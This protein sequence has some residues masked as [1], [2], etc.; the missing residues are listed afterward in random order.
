MRSIQRITWLSPDMS[1]TCPH[2]ARVAHQMSNYSLPEKVVPVAVSFS[3]ACLLACER[4]RRF[5][6]QWRVS[7]SAARVGMISPQPTLWGDE[8]IGRGAVKDRSLAEL[9]SLLWTHSSNWKKHQ[10]NI[11][12][13]NFVSITNVSWIYLYENLTIINITLESSLLD[14]GIP[15]PRIFTKND[16]DLMWKPIMFLF[17]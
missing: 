4:E 6:E 13:K 9:S 2:S 8:S 1:E 17:Y 12:L 14:S 10:F 7:H 15:P 3:R 5:S 11:S 16:F